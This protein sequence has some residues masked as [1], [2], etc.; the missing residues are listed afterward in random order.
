MTQP[1]ADRPAP[2]GYA[3]RLSVPWWWWPVGLGLALFLGAQIHS[4][5]PGVRSW[6]PYLV[7]GLLAVVLLG[8]L[9]SGRVRADGSGVGGG[10]HRLVM[11]DVSSVEELDAVHTR[12]ALG[13]DADPRG[14]VFQRP[15]VH[16]SVK[17]V[18]RTDDPPYLIL[19]TRRPTGL[20]AA[21]VALA[22]RPA[23][24]DSRTPPH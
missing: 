12:D 3:E 18:G 24:P 1:P 6:L 15:W 20:A 8:W 11:S 19:S 16:T 7:L 4:G 10:R 22:T 21:I 23:P 5:Y 17:V 9:G 14:L 13:R 2:G